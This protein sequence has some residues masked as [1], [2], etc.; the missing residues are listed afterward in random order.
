M[1]YTRDEDDVPFVVSTLIDVHSNWLMSAQC[2][3]VRPKIVDV[4]V[5][6][7]N[8]TAAWSLQ[9]TKLYAALNSVLGTADRYRTLLAS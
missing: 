8:V 7:P 2:V 9:L 5:G 6:G 1:L 3:D 4:R